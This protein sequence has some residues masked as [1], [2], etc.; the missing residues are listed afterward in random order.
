MA[1]CEAV[2]DGRKR[3][4]EIRWIVGRRIEQGTPAQSVVGDDQHLKVLGR[5]KDLLLRTTMRSIVANHQEIEY[6][7]TKDGAK[8][9][10][11]NWIDWVDS[12]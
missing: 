11:E 4:I 7:N 5:R 6:L 8:L 1:Q 9:T 3:R 12:I 2:P 10:E